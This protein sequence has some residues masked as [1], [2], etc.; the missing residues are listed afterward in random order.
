MLKIMVCYR[1]LQLADDEI[2]GYF[3]FWYFIIKFLENF[4][5]T[6]VFWRFFLGRFLRDLGY[7]LVN[8]N[9]NF[10]GLF[11]DMLQVFDKGGT[12]IR[13]KMGITTQMHLWLSCSLIS[14]YNVI[15]RWNFVTFC[16]V[17]VMW[18]CSSLNFFMVLWIFFVCTWEHVLAEVAISSWNLK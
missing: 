6:F 4:Y 11:Q 14:I 3:K 15:Q 7:C 18:T 13:I 8:N 1:F 16:N 10:Q 2:Q 17:V 9:Y 5:F 12:R